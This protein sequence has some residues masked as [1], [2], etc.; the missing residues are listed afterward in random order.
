[1]V[2]CCLRGKS[3]I[4]QEVIDLNFDFL[5]HQLSDSSDH[6]GYT[7][8]HAYSNNDSKQYDC[9]RTASNGELTICAKYSWLIVE[10]AGYYTNTMVLLIVCVAL[11]F[12][13][14]FLLQECG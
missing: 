11:P 7:L 4:N 3:W 12:I 1:M 9:C 8:C 10:Y 14:V 2:C 5:L 6:H 13:R